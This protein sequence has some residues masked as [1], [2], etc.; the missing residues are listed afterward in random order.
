MTRLLITTDRIQHYGG[1][2]LVV[3][4]LA[5]W[6]LEQGWTVDLI[7]GSLGEPL[8]SELLPLCSQ[9]RL[10]L[11]LTHQATMDP[12]DY[13]LIW[14]THS[15]LPKRFL[16]LAL[17]GSDF[18]PLFWMH[19]GSLEH[20]ESVLLRD[21][22]R[23]LATRIVTVSSRTEERVV[24]QGLPR[25]KMVIFDNP[26]PQ[27]FVHHEDSRLSGTLRRLLIV[28]NHAP[29]EVR[30]FM[31]LATKAG[32][33]V[34]HVGLGGD[35]VARVTPEILQKFDAVVT[36]GKT[37]QYCLVMGIPVYSY[38]HFGGV[39]WLDDHNFADEAAH[40]FSGFRT[41][42]R[43]SASDLLQEI[44]GGYVGAQA[45]AQEKRPQHAHHYSLDR[46]L[47]ELLATTFERNQPSQVSL[48]LEA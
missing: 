19:M 41:G 23:D 26:V 40:N 46:Q 47:R 8:T 13:D 6:F 15:V 10:S 14:V 7:A 31:D 34:T 39:G 35:F 3:L 25:E 37:T 30:H 16:E 38:D 28:S 29:M 5:E 45:W 9:G 33:D 4:E 21:I 42:R 18:P 24:E 32:I 20:R 17:R 11:H 2:E 44:L 12:R 43:L 48:D 1:A 27:N 36:I 22:E